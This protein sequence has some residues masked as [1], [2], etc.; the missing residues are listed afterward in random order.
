MSI[1]PSCPHF[2]FSVFSTRPPTG[3]SHLCPYYEKFLHKE[4][5][6]NSKLNVLNATHPFT[7]DTFLVLVL[8]LDGMV[9]NKKHCGHYLKMSS[10]Q[11][12]G[13]L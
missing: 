7:L 1:M 13:I 3:S 6:Q 9:P 12:Q 5:I 4:N 2:S 10:I 8:D 11:Q